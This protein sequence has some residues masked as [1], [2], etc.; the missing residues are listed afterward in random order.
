MRADR[1]KVYSAWSD[2]VDPGGAALWLLAARQLGPAASGGP[3]GL[4]VG[5]QGRY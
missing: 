5:E 2:T 4:S 1:T 3:G